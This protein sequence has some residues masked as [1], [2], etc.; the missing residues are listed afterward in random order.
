MDINFFRKIEEIR[1]SDSRYSPDAYEFVM[2]ALWFTQKKLKQAGHI[3]GRQLLE[4][5]RKFA[6]Q[7][8]GP[9]AKAVFGHWGI[10]TT[11]DLG[12]IV[13]NMIDAG[14]MR[15]TETDKKSDF[16]NVYAFD[17]ALDVFRTDKKKPGRAKILENEKENLLS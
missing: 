3:N 12:E 11:N 7:Q 10:K 8:Y 2:Q 5:I 13:F 4:G 17:L 16:D 6:I 1:N 15:K 14:L 9:L